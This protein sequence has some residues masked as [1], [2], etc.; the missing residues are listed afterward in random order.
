MLILQVKL[1]MTSNATENILHAIRIQYG[2]G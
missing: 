1:Q 2:A